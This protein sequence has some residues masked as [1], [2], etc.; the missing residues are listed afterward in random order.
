MS[1]AHGESKRR[2][3]S[4][5]MDGRPAAAGISSPARSARRPSAGRRE[6]A[7]APPASRP[8]ANGAGPR[9]RG[10]GSGRESR[11]RRLARTALTSSPTA[12]AVKPM[13]RTSV[14]D[15]AP[16]TVARAVSVGQA[17]LA[18]TN[19]RHATRTASSARAAT[20]SLVRR[21]TDGRRA[22]PGE[23]SCGVRTDLAERAEATPHGRRIGP[24]VGGRIPSLTDATWLGRLLE[25]L[26]CRRAAADHAGVQEMQ[27]QLVG[28]ASVL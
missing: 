3:A 21:L 19:S 6:R 2:M 9:R 26:R 14:A 12:R 10:T 25:A 4:H 27:G 15:G 11:T 20:A 5:S 7:T 1:L 17:T 18:K 8:S 16:G 23:S 13:T 22:W 28:Q 24:E